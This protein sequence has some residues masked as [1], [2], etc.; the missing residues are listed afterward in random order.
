MPPK[1]KTMKNILFL[2]LF[3]IIIACSP[4]VTTK[5][6]ESETPLDFKEEVFVLGLHETPPPNG[7]LIGTVK[8]GDSG[9]SVNCKWD[10]VIEKAKLEA[11]KT[12][13]NVL[14]ITEHKTPDLGSS[15]HRIKADIYKLSDS[16]DIS[17][18]TENVTETID[19]TWDYAL[20]NIYRPRNYTGSMVGYNLYLGDSLI[21]RVKNNFKTQIKIKKTGLNTLWAK[22]ESKEEVPIDIQLGKEYYIRCGIGMG[23]M[24][25]RPQIELVDRKTGSVEY[26][27]IKS[28]K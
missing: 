24:V 28:K 20:L 17:K 6:N 12:G 4:K 1:L 16:N 9:F 8:I 21:C 7:K 15:C 27:Q 26:N 22:T 25:G 13:G 18:L 3:S 14:K 19:S 2:L 23:V 10:K 5:V 11:R